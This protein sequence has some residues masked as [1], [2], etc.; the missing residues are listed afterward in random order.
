MNQNMRRLILEDFMTLKP[1]TDIICLIWS[2]HSYLK[3]G[4][5]SQWIP[6]LESVLDT[7]PR[8]TT[9]IVA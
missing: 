2:D 3:G 9:S 7:D 1:D 6:L 4:L 8:I 5:S